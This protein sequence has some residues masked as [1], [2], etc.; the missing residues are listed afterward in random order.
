MQSYG[1]SNSTQWL[2][3]RG[4]QPGAKLD[5][6]NSRSSKTEKPAFHLLKG[7]TSLAHLPQFK[8]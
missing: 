2:S 4:K 7:N 5:Q 8:I 6:A 3:S 1:D